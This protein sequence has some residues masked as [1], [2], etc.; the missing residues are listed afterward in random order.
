VALSS[1]KLLNCVVT[2]SLSS[3]AE[4]HFTTFGIASDPLTHFVVVLAA[5]VHDAGH[6]GMTN[7]ELIDTNHTLSQM[8]S[9]KSIAECHSIYLTLT[10]LDKYK[11]L[12]RSIYKTEEECNR[13]RDLLCH[14]VLA[15]DIIGNKLDSLWTLAF[16]SMAE[17]E[18]DASSLLNRRASVALQLIIQASDVAHTMQH[19]HVYT[20]WNEKLF[21]ERYLA[22]KSGLSSVDPSLRWYEGELSFLDN[23]VIPL[24]KRLRECKIYGVSSEEYY[25]FA[26]ENRREWERKGRDIVSAFQL[27]ASVGYSNNVTRECNVSSSYND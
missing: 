23:Y 7:A 19:W 26:L 10:T 6:P 18:H 2:G 3:D 20:K 14:S 13:F 17:S 25:G 1:L 15:T 11:L 21:V 22:Y 16:D 9:Q 12:Q 24:A 5:I 4:R 8:Y 27:R